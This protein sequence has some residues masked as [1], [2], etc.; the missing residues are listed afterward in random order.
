MISLCVGKG[1]QFVVRAV[2]WS[3]EMKSRLVYIRLSGTDLYQKGQTSIEKWY[4]LLSSK[5]PVYIPKI[6]KNM[7]TDMLWNI[8]IWDSNTD[9]SASS[10][11]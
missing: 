7:V 3:W 8:L 5:Q 6:V 11:L 10:K 1:C 4:D 2:R 9:D